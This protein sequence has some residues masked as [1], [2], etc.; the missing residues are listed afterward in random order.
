[1]MTAFS[2]Q[3]H[4]QSPMPAKNQSVNFSID[5]TVN[6]GKECKLVIISLLS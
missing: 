1:M 2:N 6:G 4:Q 3:Y 5:D